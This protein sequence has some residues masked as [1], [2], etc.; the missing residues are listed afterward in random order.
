MAPRTSRGVT[1]LQLSSTG[2]NRASQQSS[3]SQ[4]LGLVRLRDSAGPVT[5]PT[6]TH[7]PSIRPRRLRVSKSMVTA[8][9]HSAIQ[10]LWKTLTEAE[11]SGVRAREASCTG[12]GMVVSIP[13]VVMDGVVRVAPS[14]ATLRLPFARVSSRSWYRCRGGAGSGACCTASVTPQC[15]ILYW[16]A[17]AIV[18][19]PRQG[20]LGTWPVLARRSH[21]ATVHHHP[22]GE[23]ALHHPCPSLPRSSKAR[24]THVSLP[25][26]L[27]LFPGCG[28]SLCFQM[29]P[30]FA[31]AG[32]WHLR[33]VSRNVVD[34]DAGF[35]RGST[36]F[37][38]QPDRHPVH[39]H[40]SST[41]RRCVS[42]SVSR[43]DAV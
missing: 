33:D 35:M 25:P 40:S 7:H 15:T 36:P 31:S 23:G 30:E 14:G 18:G 22:H 12:H 42:S 8:R 32:G 19:G 5:Q 6:V 2:V 38:P 1:R 24:P 29:A 39:A 28:W 26:P 27:P 11:R 9:V 3:L 10:A 43:S 4:T 16:R 13:W 37:L 34:I 20:N 17:F 41:L 21:P